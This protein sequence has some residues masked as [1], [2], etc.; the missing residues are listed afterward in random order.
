M[1]GVVCDLP[2]QLMCADGIVGFDMNVHMVFVSSRFIIEGCYP[3]LHDYD[4]SLKV[5]RAG[6]A[7]G[8][9]LPEQRIYETPEFGAQ[10]T[11]LLSS[12]AAIRGESIRKKKL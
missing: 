1:G 5:P 11:V 8:C 4:E 6:N 12:F 9:V 3:S 7:V 10:R 2:E